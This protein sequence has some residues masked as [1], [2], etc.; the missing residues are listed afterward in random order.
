MVF[1]NV[2][3]RISGPVGIHREDL[4]ECIE[5]IKIV[6][7]K[8]EDIY[9]YPEIDK[10]SVFVSIYSDGTCKV[11]VFNGGIPR[12]LPIFPR[13]GTA[14][15]FRFASKDTLPFQLCIDWYGIWEDTR[16]YTEG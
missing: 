14:I 3:L 12:T 16:D 15:I 1:K 5:S 6:R 8:Y 4:S 11:L 2:T 7:K 9:L 13:P 10:S